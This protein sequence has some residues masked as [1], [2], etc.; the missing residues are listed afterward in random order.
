MTLSLHNTS[1]LIIECK[2]LQNGGIFPQKYTHRGE[3]ISPEFI[4]KNVS[5]KGKTISIIFD[6]IDQAMNHWMIWNIPAVNIIPGNLAKD[7]RLSNL[8]NAVQ[9]SR[10]RGPNPPKGIRHKYQF[11]LYVLDC[12]ITIKSKANKEE[13]EKAMENHIIQY[14]CLYGYY[15]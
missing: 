14:G 11:N 12:E 13:L 7:K 2:D 8:G 5:S 10:Y 9:K 15:E 6:D 3:E 1:E 4:L